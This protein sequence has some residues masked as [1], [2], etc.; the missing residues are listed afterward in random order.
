M[1]IIICQGTNQNSVGFQILP[2]A[3]RVG[4][5]P[6]RNQNCDLCRLDIEEVP[7]VEFVYLVTFHACRERVTEGDSGLCC[8][9]VMSFGL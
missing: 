5:T 4:I 3:I 9:C 7:L 1:H 6:G 2:V 8:A